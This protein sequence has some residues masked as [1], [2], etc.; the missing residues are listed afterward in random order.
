MY[1]KDIDWEVKGKTS[2]P[3]ASD[4]TTRTPEEATRALITE[5]TTMAIT[6]GT[7]TEAETTLPA[8]NRVT[9]QQ[10]MTTTEAV[11]SEP[12]TNDSDKTIYESFYALVDK[13]NNN[14][15]DEGKDNM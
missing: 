4:T 14:D 8:S 9:R 7:T 15:D 2:D 3:S 1:D 12:S 13:D 11:I 10:V 6:T 5:D